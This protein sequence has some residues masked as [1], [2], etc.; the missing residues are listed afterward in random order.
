MIRR[1]GNLK[2][3]FCASITK[4]FHRGELSHPQKQAVIKLIERKR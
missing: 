2:K 1:F 3:P 4:A